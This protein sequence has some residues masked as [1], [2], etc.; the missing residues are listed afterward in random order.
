MRLLDLG[1]MFL[2]HPPFFIQNLHRGMNICK[3]QKK[4]LPLHYDT[5]SRNN[6]YV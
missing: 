1:G 5:L 3:Y 2:R 6:L 4:V